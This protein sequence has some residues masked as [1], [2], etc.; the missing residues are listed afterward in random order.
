MHLVPAGGEA[1]LFILS[2]L[3]DELLDNIVVDPNQVFEQQ[4]YVAR[5]IEALQ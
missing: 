1:A 5:A 3:L 4:A 2:F